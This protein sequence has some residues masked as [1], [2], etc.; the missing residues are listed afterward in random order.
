MEKS[1]ISLIYFYSNLSRIFSQCPPGIPSPKATPLSSLAEKIKVSY[2]QS[3]GE[4]KCKS[5]THRAPDN[6]KTQFNAL[7]AT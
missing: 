6:N 1:D 2:G 5:E 7:A 4:K 3:K